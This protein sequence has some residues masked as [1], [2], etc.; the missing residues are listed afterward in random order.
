MTKEQ[1]YELKHKRAEAVA[2][3]KALLAAKNMEGYAAKMAEVDSFN[4][5]I[6]ASEKLLAEEGRFEAGEAS[7]VTLAAAQAHKK[8]EEQVEKSLDE[9]RGSNEYAQAF[10]KAM[11]GQVSVKA[12]RSME[13]L[14][15]L[16]KALTEGTPA[17]GGFLVPVDVDNTIQR[18]EKEWFDLSAFFRVE[19]VSTASGWRV[20]ETGTRSAL[21]KVLEMGTIGKV[22]QPSFRKVEYSVS[23]YADRLPVSREL[24]EDNVANLLQ[25]VAEW[26]GPKYVLTKNA[27][28]LPMLNALTVTVALEAGKEDKQL[29]NALITKL[30]TAHSRQASLLTNQ[31]GYAEMDGWEDK[32]GRPMLVPNPVDPQVLR[33]RGRAVAYGDDSE[34]PLV[35]GLIPLY[36]GNLKALGSLFVR[37]GIELAATDVGGDAWATDSVELRAICRLDA[38]KVDG[39][40]AFKATIS[41]AAG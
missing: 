35:G 33:Y 21:P 3:A 37:K 2:A 8:A 17:D 41:P 1:I 32:N 22:E 5:E 28:L 34:M 26:F 11:R 27:L 40:A 4:G 14:S 7:L 12:G 23:K 18:I 38:Q 30:N 16:Y 29:R 15:P 20:V 10:A 31:S 36:V 9:L 25:Y 19:K 24:V 39:T 6:D 13:E